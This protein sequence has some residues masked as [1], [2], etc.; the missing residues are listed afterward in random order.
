MEKENEELIDQY[1]N[2]E[3]IEEETLKKLENNK[4]FMEKVIEKT[5]DYKMYYYCSNNIKRDTGFL[6]FLMKRFPNNLDFLCEAG[7]Y[8]FKNNK[9]EYGSIEIAIILRAIL[10]SNNDERYTKYE[11]IR[12]LMYSSLRLQ[13]ERV[14][15][16]QKDDYKFQADIG[17]G[18]WYIF[19]L[20][21]N[22]ELVTNYY[23]KKMIYEIF[24]E[25]Y[26]ALDK[27]LHNQ[28][29][30]VEEI[31]DKGVYNVL[32]STLTI[33]DNM[34]A[35]YVAVHKNLLKKVIDK[36]FTVIKRWDKYVD[37]EEASK[38]DDISTEVEEYMEDKYFISILSQGELLSL[39]GKQL[40]IQDKLIQY[41][42]ID[43]TDVEMIEEDEDNYYY[44]ISNSLTDK[45]NFNNVKKIIKSN[46][47]FN[48]KS[49]EEGKKEG[50]ILKLDDYRNKQN[51]R[52]TRQI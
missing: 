8:Y 51:K 27:I 46:L 32:I 42:L 3:Y 17:L 11:M 9:D 49:I 21:K 12:E 18:F 44:I 48:K 25:D 26:Y 20:Y 22:N 52:K 41:K 37:S 38:Y 45:I 15:E 10:K 23:A 5:N 30:S 34:L 35:A 4:Y 7:D 36:Y 1:I 39:I 16:E 19:D 43:E 47:F 13:V 24:I 40:G 33:Y 50:K 14:K 2:G 28:Y 29:S 6:R 31:E